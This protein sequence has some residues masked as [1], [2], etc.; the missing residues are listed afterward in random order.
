MNASLK[1][2]VCDTC[3]LDLRYPRDKVGV[4]KQLSLKVPNVKFIFETDGA[5]ELTRTVLN[6]KLV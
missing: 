4:L 1:K 6:G 5:P 3:L 2:G